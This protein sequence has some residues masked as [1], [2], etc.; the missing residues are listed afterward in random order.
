MI[1]VALVAVGGVDLVDASSGLERETR[2]QDIGDGLHCRPCQHL[3]VW[4]S[5]EMQRKP[6]ALVFQEQRWVVLNELDQDGSGCAETRRR[7]M[8]RQHAPRIARLAP[9]NARGAEAVWC[10]EIIQ[11]PYSPSAHERKRT[12]ES[13][14]DGVQQIPETFGHSHFLRSLSDL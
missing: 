5:P 6:H 7:A 2:P 11:V 10:E 3:K 8:G 4:R 9:M 14:T 12:V 13:Y 1:A